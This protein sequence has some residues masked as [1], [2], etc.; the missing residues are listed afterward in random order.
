MT[1]RSQ[2]RRLARAAG[3]E[4]DYVS[5]H[6]K[7][8]LAGVIHLP[9]RT[10]FDV[11]ANVGQFAASISRKFPAATVHSFE[12]L[13]EAFAKLREEAARN[14]GRIVPVNTALGADAGTVSMHSHLDHS[15]SSSLLAATNLNVSLFP[16]TKRTSEIDV[17][18]TTLDAY[19]ENLSETPAE[20]WLLKLDVQGYEDRVLA[21]ARDTISRCRACMLEIGLFSLY[22]GQADFTRLTN[23]LYESGMYYAGNIQ[24]TAERTGKVVYIDAI[25]T[26]P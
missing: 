18:I 7:E 21:G 14:P 1:L 22:E 24:Q 3:V 15:P 19:V 17:P 9:I 6:P 25:F 13:P 16:Q 26:R 4:L 12:P 8:T 20:D 11:G 2:I 23:L 10:V 5:R